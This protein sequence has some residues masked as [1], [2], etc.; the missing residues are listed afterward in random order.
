MTPSEVLRE[1]RSFARMM[2]EPVPQWADAIEA[3]MREPVAE[4]SDTQ[5]RKILW[6]TY[7]H[8]ERHQPGTKL[9]AFPPDA[10]AELLSLTEQL[11]ARDAEIQ[12]L[13]EAVQ[14]R[15]GVIERVLLRELRLREAITEANEAMRDGS[16]LTAWA[17][18]VAALVPPTD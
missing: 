15:D 14:E 17:I 5:S 6:E 9:F 8:A 3:A 11:A 12:R 7:A 2:G 10:Q 4:V 1:M 18:L 13:Q 16:D